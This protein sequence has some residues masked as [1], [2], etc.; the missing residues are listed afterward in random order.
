MQAPDRDAGTP[1]VPRH[2]PLERHDLF[3]TNRR[4]GRESNYEIA[5]VLFPSFLLLW[6]Q[7]TLRARQSVNGM[8]KLEPC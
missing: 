6:L 2:S 1:R 8:R 3:H 5:G 7:V 4:S